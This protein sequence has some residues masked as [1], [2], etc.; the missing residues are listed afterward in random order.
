MTYEREELLGRGD[1]LAL[2]KLHYRR[3]DTPLTYE[4]VQRTTSHDSEHQGHPPHASSHTA[5]VGCLAILHASGKPDRVALILNFRP[6]IGAPSV[7]LPGG[8]I[9]VGE[10]IE[11][12]AVRERGGGPDRR[13]GSCGR[14]RGWLG[15]CGRRR[16]F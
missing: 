7:E 4:F 1:W 3:G 2:K 16:Q 12:A 13:C 10:T 14:R 8:L 5:G 11:E 15:G 6:T 9:D